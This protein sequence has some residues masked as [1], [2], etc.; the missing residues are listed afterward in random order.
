VD[1]NVFSDDA[2]RQIQQIGLKVKQLEQKIGLL[3]GAPN[4][5]RTQLF[6]RIDSNISD[7]TYT[8]DQV[9][10]GGDGLLGT[11]P[12]DPLRWDSTA[13]GYLYS[14]D[15]ATDTTGIFPVFQTSDGTDMF[16]S[17]SPGVEDEFRHV[18][19]VTADGTDAVIGADRGDANYEFS[20]TI[21]MFDGQDGDILIISFADA[22]NVTLE[23]GTNHVYYEVLKS[24]GGAWEA[25]PKRTGTWPPSD[26]DD[27]QQKFPLLVAEVEVD[28]TDAV[29]GQELFHNPEMRPKQFTPSF[30]PIHNN[31]F[32]KITAGKVRLASGDVSLA[33]V[34]FATTSNVIVYI[35]IVSNA[36]T[37]TPTV[38]DTEI[39]SAASITY[40]AK[41]AD[42]NLTRQIPLGFITA[43]TNKYTPYHT[44]DLLLGTQYQPS[45]HADVRP[46]IDKSQVQLLGQESVTSVGADM[47][48][49]LSGHKMTWDWNGGDLE[50][51]TDDG[52]FSFGGITATRDQNAI[53]GVS[54]DGTNLTFTITEFQDDCTAGLTQD[55]TNVDG[56]NIIIAFPGGDTTGATVNV[57]EDFLSS[58]DTATVNEIDINKRNLAIQ[59]TDGLV[60]AFT[61]GAE[62]VESSLTCDEEWIEIEA[63]GRFKH[64]RANITGVADP[65]HWTSVS[66]DG[67]SWTDGVITGT[68][69]TMRL[70]INRHP[71]E[72]IIDGTSV[73]QP[74]D[75]TNWRYEDCTNSGSER[76]YDSS[77]DGVFT[78]DGTCWFL[79]G[80]T[81]ATSD[82]TL[83]SVDYTD[84]SDC[85]GDQTNE[86]WKECP[87]PGSTEYYL[88]ASASADLAAWGCIGSVW[89]KI[90]NTE[91]STALAATVTDVIDQCD[92]A[93]DCDG[94]VGWLLFDNFAA[95]GC[96]S[97]TG[98]LNTNIWDLVYDPDGGGGSNV[99][100]GSKLRITAA[101]TTG[102]YGIENS[103]SAW[104]GDFFISCDFSNISFATLGQ[105]TSWIG[106]VI[107]FQGGGVMNME[108]NRTSAD[109]WES[110]G[111]VQATSATSGTL[112]IERKA[113]SSTVRARYNGTSLHTIS[114]SNAITRIIIRANAAGIT[115]QDVAADISDV[116]G[117]DAIEPD[118]V[119]WDPTGKACP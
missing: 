26:I 16:W 42:G 104:T 84:C 51:N 36:G 44:G 33:A 88:A 34:E 31:G 52:T 55:M 12:T 89:T 69:M 20:D 81:D 92:G 15:D 21:T 103:R 76:V 118:V 65:K 23:S 109:N 119:A 43:A 78:D 29:V 102:E 115:D 5:R 75:E 19:K 95:G 107:F 1:Y 10:A 38:T 68:D 71:Y 112:S 17:F 80:E 50:D 6:A 2:V 14:M 99:V 18:F 40:S 86:I 11:T 83:P 113:G 35:E 63:G 22:E 27:D 116:Q 8:A 117:S 28:G 9:I 49:F 57:N 56:T 62:A 98:N 90:Y 4:Q 93:V 87:S 30:S 72:F 39:K 111:N 32:V 106:L 53:T 45:F 108:R 70:D 96:Q 24:T 94:L 79:I 85:L 48:T 67:T 77:T 73:D 46:S 101:S 47:T 41:D 25:T 3:G 74:T 58:V 13:I 110:L 59:T 60:Q 37:D 82:H 54:S 64:A 66:H 97:S 105:G 7:Q 100:S 114:N 91:T 61:I